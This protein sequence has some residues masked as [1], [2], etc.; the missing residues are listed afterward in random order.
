MSDARQVLLCGLGGQGVVL[1]G[2]LLGAA[3][4]SE[5]LE[6]SGTSSY[7][8]AARG[9]QCRSEVVLSSRPIGFPFVTHADVLVA[10]SQSAYLRYITWTRS[11]DGVVFYDPVDVEPAVDA[12][13]KHIAV[14][15]TDTAH[16][17]LGSRLGANIVMLGAVAGAQNLVSRES[18][19]AV[20]RERSPVRFREQNLLAL[21]AGL[22]LS[23]GLR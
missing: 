3:G 17:I 9:G 13:Q 16:Q 19:E 22:A 5:G 2:R 14:P 11:P 10:L 6:V 8:A 1:A 23:P 7:G 12:V 20:V 21:D 18:L 15:A 4:F